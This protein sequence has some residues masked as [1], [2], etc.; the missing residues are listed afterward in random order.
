MKKNL[1]QWLSWQESLHT[2]TIDLGLDRIRQ[3]A[4]RMN[5]L[6]PDFP[7][8]TVAG[9][10]GKGSTVALL[11]SILQAAGYQ[12]GTY[13][14]PHILRYN[15]RI[16]LNGCPADDESICAAFAAID[17]ARG[18]ISLTYFEFGTL[19]AMWL[20]QRAGLDVVVLEV[21]L[22][23]R[24]D[25][26]NLW[27]AEV[28]IVT[29]I[30]I[31]H[32]AW[33][34]DNR[35]MIGREKAAIARSGKALIC[36]DPA[37]PASIAKVAAEVNARYLQYGVDFF[38]Q[39]R[40][41]SPQR[42]SLHY[43]AMTAHKRS[44]QLLWRDLPLPALPG[45]VQLLNAAC[46]LSALYQLRETL[47]VSR[48]ALEQGLCNVHLPGRLQKLS[49]DP[50]I[51]LDVA[52]NPQAATQLADWLQKNPTDGRTYVLFSVLSDKDING[53][54]A[55]LSE[56]V[57]EWHFFPLEDQRA[58]PLYAMQAAMDEQHI[59]MAV[60]HESLKQARQALEPQLN[61]T[62]RVVVFGSFLVVSN[63]LESL[64]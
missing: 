41:A 42:F 30:G 16:T 25:A 56:V 18:D 28:A 10:N 36:G 54:I 5:L 39:H 12:V 58:M 9:T 52:H 48:R 26:A 19:A 59:S 47:P 21:G 57:D 7:L 32:V 4:K 43:P 40:Q 37:P 61:R 35:E 49:S 1:A 31:D 38:V 34:G 8:I 11:D 22:G 51:L 50:D 64:P 29:R 63:M 53:I 2:S 23:G 3:V 46:A 20:F 60:S 13:T 17:K 33:L 15:E 24:L 44:Q 6:Q 62:D 27:D 55:A 45:A 14:S